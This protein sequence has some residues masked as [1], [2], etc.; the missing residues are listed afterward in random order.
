MK[1]HDPIVAATVSA[2]LWP[3]VSCAAALLSPRGAELGEQLLLV[4]AKA[5]LRFR[6][7]RHFPISCAHLRGNH[8]T[9]WSERG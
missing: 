3:V 1:R 4:L 2:I 5:R 8:G 9:L 6:L 7:V